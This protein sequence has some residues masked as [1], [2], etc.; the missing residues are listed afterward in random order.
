[1]STTPKRRSTAPGRAPI[2]TQKPPKKD[3]A[4]FAGRIRQIIADLIAGDSH[5]DLRR[6][7]TPRPSPD[8][9][10]IRLCS[11]F[12]DVTSRLAHIDERLA[13]D[14]ADKEEINDLKAA[15]EPLLVQHDQLLE[16]IASITARTD[17]GRRMKARAAFAAMRTVEEIECAALLALVRSA[18][19]DTAELPQPAPEGVPS[20]ISIIAADK[21]D[22]CF[23]L[24]PCPCASPCKWV[25]AH[26][27]NCDL[28]ALLS[29]VAADP[30]AADH[31]GAPAASAYQITEDPVGA[32][33]R[34]YH[35][36]EEA[37]KNTDR[38]IDSLRAILTRR[39]DPPD[40]GNPGDNACWRSGEDACRAGSVAVWR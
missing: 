1:M 22:P 13:G 9:R 12:I 37:S 25:V 3:D 39:P 33:Y 30:P 4:Y 36:A 34:R 32:L 11:E 26:T 40:D 15:T 5:P 7:G 18:L 17:Q 38:N 21:W 2:V 23:K 29:G 10:L 6:D 27:P 35:E 28:P 19:R 16:P 31:P 8:A 24:G 20:M 14:D